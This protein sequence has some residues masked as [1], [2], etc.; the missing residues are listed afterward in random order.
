M[1]ASSSTGSDAAD[2][3]E[4]EEEKAE[5]REDVAEPLKRNWHKERASAC[6]GIRRCAPAP[7]SAFS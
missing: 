3:E 5:K 2:D 1:S 7:R 6:A 4:D